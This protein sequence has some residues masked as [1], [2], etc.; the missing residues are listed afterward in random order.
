MSMLVK[1]N[2]MRR[3]PPCVIRT[4]T[5]TGAAVVSPL[6]ARSDCS[7]V[8]TGVGKAIDGLFFLGDDDNRWCRGI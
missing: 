8:E 2:P 4:E 6:E 5:E 7:A 1:R 3:Q